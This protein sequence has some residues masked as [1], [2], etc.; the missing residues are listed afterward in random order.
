M[1][2]AKKHL[3]FILVAL[4]AL[5]LIIFVIWL[6]EKRIKTINEKSEIYSV[7]TFSKKTL[8]T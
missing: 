6:F 1:N 7:R 5:L 3:A 2:Y 4:L 8:K